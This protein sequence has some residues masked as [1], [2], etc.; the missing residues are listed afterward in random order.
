MKID[1]PVNIGDIVFAVVGE[2]YLGDKNKHYE[3]RICKV[4]DVTV[5][6]SGRYTVGVMEL[7]RNIGHTTILDYDVFYDVK[8]AAKKLYDLSSDNKR[9]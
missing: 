9:G 3:V 8:D 5:F 1:L 6:G 2:Q 4:C 7:N